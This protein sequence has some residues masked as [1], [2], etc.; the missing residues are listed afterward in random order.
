MCISNRFKTEGVLAMRLKNH[1]ISIDIKDGI[2]CKLYDCE[3]KNNTNLT[4]QTGSTGSISYTYTT[5]DITVLGSNKDFVPYIDRK[6]IYSS[7]IMSD[8]VII[9]RDDENQIITKYY[10]DSELVIDVNCN[11]RNISELAVNF[12]LNFMGM[13]GTHYAEQ[14]LPTTPYTSANGKYMYY[15]MARP[16][17]RF[18]TIAAE[19]P[20]DGWRIKYSEVSLCHYI[21]GIQFFASF[22]R[23]FGGS[24]RKQI[25]LRI[26]FSKNIEEVYSTVGRIYEAPYCINVISGG[27]GD[28][29][30]KC[31]SDTDEVKITA[32]SGKN[33]HIRPYKDGIITYKSDEYGLHTVTALK[34]G[35]CGL[36]STIWSGLDYD[37]LFEKSCDAIKQ[38]YHVD[39][40][41]CEGGM[42]LWAMLVYMN[43]TGSRKY[44]RIVQNELKII[45]GEN[46]YNVPRKTI[47]P[48]PTDKFNAYHISDSDRI[49]E[50]F[51][52]ISILLEAYKLYKEKKY[53]DHAINALDELMINRISVE[54]MIF[55]YNEKGI[56]EDF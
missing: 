46:G 9:C 37:I 21:D 39:D 1:K 6:N 14:L 24:G 47:L 22:D 12:D 27:F 18:M 13:K 10:L 7:M 4:M 34:K 54:G 40:N 23:Q 51:V 3:D 49:Q 42:F 53:I 26:F 38:P 43:K 8:N 50:Q 55:R 56:V 48:Y 35:E 44:D 2:I 25:K 30:I 11:N 32:P 52:G 5:D 36:N 20:A 15:T 45:M 41:L 31:S 28:S 29:V 33:V 17:G 19:T 16:N